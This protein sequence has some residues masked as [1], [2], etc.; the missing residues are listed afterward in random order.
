MA[1]LADLKRC[2]QCLLEKLP[3]E[4]N[5]C[6]ASGDG[7]QWKCRACQSLLSSQYHAANRDKVLA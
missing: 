2:N 6:A 1:D 7:L 5:K 3:S 4:F